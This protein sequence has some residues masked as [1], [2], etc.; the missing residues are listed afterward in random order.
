MFNSSRVLGAHL[1]R[2]TRRRSA[3][4]AGSGQCTITF[5][6]NTTGTVTGHAT[7]SMNL[8]TS[9]CLITI[10]RQADGA[11][12]STDDA[13]KEFVDGNLAWLKNDEVGAR[14]VGAT[15]EVCRTHTLNTS[16]NPDTFIDSADPCVTVPDN[17]APAADPDA[18]EFLLQDLVLGR[19]TVDGLAPFPPGFE[20]DPDD[21]TA[22]LTLQPGP[23]DVT[24]TEAFVNHALYRLIVITCNTT[25]EELVDSTVTLNGDTRETV[26]PGQLGGID[27]NALCTLPGANYDNLTRGT[28][29]PSV[30]L[31]DRSPLFP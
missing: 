18:G 29:N 30:E 19:Y 24:I 23:K 4:A 12:G 26:K 2:G 20:P 13:V 16:T 21:V 25:T 11:G 31:P 22:E 9:E 17:S 14:L 5:T 27:Q 7:V 1:S 3:R 8:T 6:S 28:Y 15:F 10:V